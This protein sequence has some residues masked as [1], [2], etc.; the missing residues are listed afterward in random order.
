MSI[1]VYEY[2]GCGTCRKALA[3]LDKLGVDYKKIA[4]RE[5]PPT[6]SE[7][8]FMLKAYEGE[9]KKLFNTSGQDYRALNIK[10]RMK[11]MTEKEAFELLSTNGNLVKRPFVISKEIGI[12]G[13]N[14]DQWKKTF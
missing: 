3:F 9:I 6:K 12:V 8:K 7:L 2:K 13:F 14:E 5:N 4:I 10:D 1:K 11:D